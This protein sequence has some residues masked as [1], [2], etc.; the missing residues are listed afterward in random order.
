MNRY[1]SVS[2]HKQTA[3]RAMEIQRKHP[4]YTKEHR[5][6][7]KS[8]SSPQSH[9]Y[10]NIETEERKRGYKSVEPALFFGLTKI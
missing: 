10:I 3:Q 1:K 7:E 2:I 9:K 6:C 4:V 5:S 8:S